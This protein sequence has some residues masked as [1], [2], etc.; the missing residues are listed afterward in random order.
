MRFLIQPGPRRPNLT[1]RV[2]AANLRQLSGDWQAIF[3]HP[4]VLVERAE[5]L[6][7]RIV[8]RSHQLVEPELDQRQE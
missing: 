7:P 1:S 4:I 8:G 6:R 3:G 2:L 5:H